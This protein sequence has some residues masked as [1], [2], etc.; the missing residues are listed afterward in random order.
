MRLLSDYF[1]SAALEEVSFRLAERLIDI[2]ESFGSENKTGSVL[3]AR[4]SQSEL[5]SMVGTSR[6][7]VNRILQTFQ[8]RGWVSISGGVLR[9]EE[10]RVGKGWVHTCRTR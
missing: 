6:Q 3:I 10:R 4:L 2:L 1:A 9:S 8:N 7:T 5:A